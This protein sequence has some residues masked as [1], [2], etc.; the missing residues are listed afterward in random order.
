MPNEPP[1]SLQT[2][3]TCAPRQ[4]EM[5]ANDV[6]HHVRRLRALIHRQPRLAGVPVGDDRARLQR[7]AGMAA[8]DELRLHDL[9]GVREGLRRRRRRRACARRRDCRRARDGSPASP[10]RARSRMSVDRRRA[11]RNRPRP[12]RPRPRPRRGWRATMAATA[13]PCQ[14]ARSI[15]MACCGADFRPFRCDSTPTQGVMTSASSS[16]VT[17]AI[18]PGSRSRRRGVDAQDVRMRMGRAQIDDMRHARQH[19]VADIVPASLQQPLEIRP[20]HRAADVGIRP[21]ER[22]ES[23]GLRSRGHDARSA[24]RARRGLDRVDD[25]L[26]AGA[27]AVIAGQML[28]DLLAVRLGLARQQILRGDQHARRAD[29][30]IAARCGR[31]RRP[32]DRRSRRCRTMP[33]MVST[34]APRACTASIRQPRTM[35]PSSRTVQAPQT[36]CSQPTWVPVVSAEVLAQ[37][38]RESCAAHRARRR[39]LPNR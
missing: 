9:V 30:R 36:P 8:E 6:L 13:S 28:A 12:A 38:I 34:D 27:A 18:T 35:S 24:A 11:P 2:T 39:G 31:R 26:I 14:Q 25:G 5:L 4:A 15:A 10:D 23:S 19:D 37:E 1:T 7:H 22:R 17:T 16:P 21:V 32:A 20:R 3:R 29:S 33:S